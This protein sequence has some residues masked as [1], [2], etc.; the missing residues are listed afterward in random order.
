MR[1]AIRLMLVDDHPVVR[2]GLQSMLREFRDIQ[3]VAEAAAGA[4]ALITVQKHEVDVALLDVRMEGMDG[5]ELASALH[6]LRSS[7]RIL[8]LTN[9]RDPAYIE[10]A[11]AAGATGYL[12]KNLSP[13]E[14]A[15]AIR[16]A[17]DGERVVSPEIVPFI[18]AHY[19]EEG[20]VASGVGLVRGADLQ[21]LRLVV[22]GAT[23][24]EI[25]VELS[26]S[27]ATIKRRLLK[28]YRC[29]N[30]SSR[31]EAVRVATQNGLV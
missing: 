14:L 10:A 6:E 19:D 12:M 26:C 29:L 24:I 28:L 3:L 9:Y 15:S 13:D 27:E 21:L 22:S 4:E 25:G 18:L 17:N 1:T 31:I 7:L 16:K 2:H 11:F 30:V 8:M 20:E 23:N 5:L